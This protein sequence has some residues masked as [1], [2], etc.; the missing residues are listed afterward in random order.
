MSTIYRIEAMYSDGCRFIP[1]GCEAGVWY[2]FGGHSFRSGSTFRPYY[3][4][5]SAQGQL[6]RLMGDWAYDRLPADERSTYRITQLTGEWEA[7]DE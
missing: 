4:R 1:Q 7:L 3:S 5:S 6:T 2:P